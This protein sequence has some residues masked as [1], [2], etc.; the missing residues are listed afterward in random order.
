[1]GFNKQTMVS[2]IKLSILV[3]DN[4]Y[5]TVTQEDKTAHCNVWNVCLLFAQISIPNPIASLQTMT[6]GG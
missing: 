1:M 3:T 2:S 4:K 5:Q 6:R